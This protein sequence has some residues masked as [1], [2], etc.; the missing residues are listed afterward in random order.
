MEYKCTVCKNTFDV[1]KPVRYVETSMPRC[2]YCKSVKVE[3]LKS[4]LNKKRFDNKDKD[5]TRDK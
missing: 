5:L 3:I 4:S 1:E 2:P